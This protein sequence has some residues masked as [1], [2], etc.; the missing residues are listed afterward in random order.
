MEKTV[1]R[2]RH[3]GIETLIIDFSGT[4]NIDVEIANHIFDIRNI[5]QLIGVKTIATGIR[6]DLA[7]NAVVLVLTCHPLKYTRASCRRS[8]ALNSGNEW[9]CS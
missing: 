2:V 5:L 3:L 8:E 7:M 9:S 4:V 6:P 1:P